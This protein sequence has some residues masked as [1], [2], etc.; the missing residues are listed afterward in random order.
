MSRDIS[1]WAVATP[2]IEFGPLTV[3]FVFGLGIEL[4]FSGQHAS[5]SI[6][7]GLLET[8]CRK[9]VRII[10]AMHFEGLTVELSGYPVPAHA[11]TPKSIPPE[12]LAEK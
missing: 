3:L 7:F 12:Q 5:A 4:S 1:Q 10:V 6:I 9:D 8:R 11:E 2:I